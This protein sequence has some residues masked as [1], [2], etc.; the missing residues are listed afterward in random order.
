MPWSLGSTSDD[1]FLKST[2]CFEGKDIVVTL[3]MDGENSNLYRDHYHARSLDSKDH[4]SRSWIKQFHAGIKNDIPEG[5]RICGENL[6][7]KHSIGYDNLKSYFYCFSIWDADNNC[8][9]WDDTV[10]YCELLDII[11]V[12]VLYRGSWDINVVK[13]IQINPEIDEGYVVRNSDSF[14]YND[15]SKNCAK[16]VKAN[17]VVSSIHWM[18]DA[19]VKNSLV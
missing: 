15:F 2:S 13:N 8:L 11:P 14:H 18:H 6:Y 17:H 10:E 1:K 5:F 16:Y 4:E 3:K 9:S 19:I 12:P 7:A